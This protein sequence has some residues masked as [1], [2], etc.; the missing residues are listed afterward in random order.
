MSLGRR[1]IQLVALAL[2][3]LALGHSAQAGFISQIQTYAGGAVPFLD[4]LSFKQFNNALGTLT[5]VTITVTEHGTVTA[6]AL[7]IGA[8]GTIT[9]FTATGSVMVTGP[10]DSMTTSRLT[11]A[12][13]TGGIGSAYPY[14]KKNLETVTSSSSTTNNV[15][16]S[17]AVAA[18]EGTGIMAYKVSADGEVSITGTTSSPNIFL[19]G[20]AS[21][22]GS[23]EIDYTFI[24]S[25]NSGPAVVPEPASIGM[26]AMGLGGA[27]VVYRRRRRAA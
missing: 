15:T 12:A 16:S 13:Y 6:T 5:K 25:N 1:P 8:A 17:G 27:L 24:A 21:L 23:V 4:S 3:V 2:A 10:D 22:S 18:Y 19:G 20:G 14:L 7:N 9:G 11:T 26:V